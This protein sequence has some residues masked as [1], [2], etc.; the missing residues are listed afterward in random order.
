[1]ELLRSFDDVGRGVRWPQRCDVPVAMNTSAEEAFGQHLDGELADECRQG[2]FAPARVEVIG[3]WTIL[4]LEQ[5]LRRGDQ[6]PALLHCA[7]VNRQDARL[8]S[9]EGFVLPEP[10]GTLAVALDRNIEPQETQWARCLGDVAVEKEAFD[11]PEG[12]GELDTAAPQKLVGRT[13]WEQVQVATKRQRRVGAESLFDAFQQ[14]LQL[15]RADVLV[16]RAP[17]Q[18]RRRDE[19]TSGLP[20]QAMR[21]C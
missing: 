10:Y 11:P 12:A 17:I 3:R 9:A 19:E 18:M 20:N 2:A 16:H 6:Q 5:P 1:M 15:P 14:H 7:S 21:S 13:P 4:F 8:L